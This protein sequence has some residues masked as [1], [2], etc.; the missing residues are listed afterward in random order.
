MLFHN[1]PHEISC[2]IGCIIVVSWLY[3]SCIMAVPG[4]GGGD[5][6]QS[7]PPCWGWRLS[8]KASRS[9]LQTDASSYLRVQLINTHRSD[10][11]KKRY[12]E[13]QSVKRQIE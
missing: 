13:P 5:A 12:L 10:N 6:R 3:H 11:K 1:N 8:P 7:G 9:Q 4:Q 2:I